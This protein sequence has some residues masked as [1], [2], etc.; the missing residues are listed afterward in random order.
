MILETSEVKLYYEKCGNGQP[1]IM[2]HGSGE[3]CTIF[4]KAISVLKNHFTVYAI[5]TRNIKYTIE[6]Q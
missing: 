6:V 2:L 3:D 4:N 5:D 1:L